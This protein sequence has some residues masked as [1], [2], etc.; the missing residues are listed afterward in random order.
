[1]EQGGRYSISRAA[2]NIQVTDP[3]AFARLRL[4][5]SEP[6]PYSGA[7]LDPLTALPKGLDTVLDTVQTQ[8]TGEEQ[9]TTW[10]IQSHSW[11]WGFGEQAFAESA[12]PRVDDRTHEKT[13]VC[14][15]PALNARMSKP[16]VLFTPMEH[17]KLKRGKWF[18]TVKGEILTEFPEDSNVRRIHSEKQ[19]RKY[20]S[21][22]GWR[23]EVSPP[24]S[25]TTR[26]FNFKYL[27]CCSR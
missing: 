21:Q 5:F 1:M 6:L 19:L 10:N 16:D 20:I 3:V 24:H 26:G 14:I 2:A 18:L 4:A 11:L 22:T 25:S 7:S 12:Q 27:S 23:K 15:G 17:M 9:Y 13:I 8:Y